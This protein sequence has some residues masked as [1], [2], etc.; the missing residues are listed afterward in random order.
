MVL[1][2]KLISD[3]VFAKL[4]RNQTLHLV[5]VLPGTVDFYVFNSETI[6]RLL[7]VSFGSSYVIYDLYLSYFT[8]LGGRML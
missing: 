3:N 7:A 5:T 6:P 4:R 8:R 1:D 2:Y